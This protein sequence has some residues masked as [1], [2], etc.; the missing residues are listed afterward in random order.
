MRYP[1]LLKKIVDSKWET[2]TLFSY[3]KANP[4]KNVIAIRH[5]VDDRIDKA[6][7]MAL[8]EHDMGVFS[9][10][11]LLTTHPYYVDGKFHANYIYQLGHE[12]GLHLDLATVSAVGRMNAHKYIIENIMNLGRIGMEIKGVSAHGSELARQMKF[13]GWEY[14][15]DY[16]E[17]E[18]SIRFEDEK[19][20]FETLTMGVHPLAEYGL[21][22][23]A[24]KLEKPN[25]I[26]DSHGEIRINR[27]LKDPPNTEEELFDFIENGSG[28][29]I[30][31]FHPQ[32]YEV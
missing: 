10:Y 12:V 32:Y 3:A 19:G 13:K 21:T 29:T 25:Y 20:E 2:T 28:K 4:N 27:D 24:I 23:D 1:E 8:L 17:R 22:Y 9:T 15:Y 14:F 18:Y 30:M 5:D 31:L 11:F 26:S 7:R 6:R 16:A